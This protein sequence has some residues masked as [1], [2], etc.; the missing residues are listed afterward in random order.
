MDNDCDGGVDE[1]FDADA[2]GALDAAACG[3]TGCDDADPTIC[4]GCP[5]IAHDGLDQDRDGGDLRDG[6]GDGHDDASLGGDD[7]DDADLHVSPSAFDFRNDGVD[8]DRDGRDG[9]APALIDAPMTVDGA[10]GQQQSTASGVALCDL[11]DDGLDDLVVSAPLLSAG[12]NTYEG[13]VGI[14]YGAGA[15]GWA[16]GMAMGTADTL[17]WGGPDPPPRPRHGRR[18]RRRGRLPGH[19]RLD[20]RARR[21][22]AEFSLAL[23]A[24]SGGTLGAT[25]GPSDAEA[26]LHYPRGAPASESARVHANGFSVADLDGDGAAEIL[27]LRSIAE[28]SD[29]SLGNGDDRL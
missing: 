19:H 5:E 6:D 22:G 23:S 18:G 21:G 24:G 17:I 27:I 1:G 2:D 25:L 12:T 4:P 29:G 16:A 11:D 13:A 20:R 15:G 28:W 3:G 9:R 26:I 8:A 14:W 7:C 10:S